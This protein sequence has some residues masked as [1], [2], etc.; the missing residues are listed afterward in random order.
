MANEKRFSSPL[1][2]YILPLRNFAEIYFYGR[3]RQNVF[4]GTDVA[5]KAGRQLLAAVDADDASTFN[6]R[7]SVNV[8][9]NSATLHNV[10][11]QT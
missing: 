10:E 8:K 6:K 3:Q 4:G 9:A 1:E 7:I 2:G 5:D 11:E